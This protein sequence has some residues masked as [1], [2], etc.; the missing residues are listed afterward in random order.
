M[1]TNLEK[2]SSLQ[3]LSAHLWWSTTR[4]RRL[5]R[6]SSNEKAR[7]MMTV[8]ARGRIP[9]PEGYFGNGA[10]AATMVVSETDLLEKGLGFAAIKI[11]E[12]VAQQTK[13]EMIKFVE[14]WVENPILYRKGSFPFSFAITSSPRHDVYGNDFGWGKPIAVRSGKSQKSD[15]KMTLYPAAVDGGIDVEVCLAP[16]TLQALENDEEFMEAF[17]V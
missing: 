5:S 16:A 15:G 3:A 6:R 1:K 17:S 14:E 12:F 10:R 11:K 4:C 8:G 13:E 9:L 7:L 2:I